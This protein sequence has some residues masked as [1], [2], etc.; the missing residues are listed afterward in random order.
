MNC[1][2]CGEEK[3]KTPV[4]KGDYTRFVDENNRLWNG[5]ICPDCYKVY[6]RERMKKTRLQKKLLNT[7]QQLDIQET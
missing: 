5:R 1:K 6:N 3:V 2:E 4:S 7:D